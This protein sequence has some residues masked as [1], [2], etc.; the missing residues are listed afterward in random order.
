MLVKL[1][2]I[3]FLPLYLDFAFFASHFLSFWNKISLIDV[4]TAELVSVPVTAVCKAINQAS[5]PQVG[6]PF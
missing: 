2:K 5:T 1:F 4:G 3:E 6:Y